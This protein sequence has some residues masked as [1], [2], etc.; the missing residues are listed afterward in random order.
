MPSAFN[1]D[2]TVDSS[3]GCKLYQ[4]FAY[5]MDALS[6]WC[7][8]YISFERFITTKYYAKRFL[9]KKKKLQIIFLILLIAFNILY[10]INII[11][12]FDISNYD[13]STIC[14]FNNDENQTIIA[15]MDLANFF[16]I[17]L[18][19]MLLFSILLI[20]TILKSR[21]TMNSNNAARE[22]RHRRKDIKLSISLLFLNLLFF[23]LNLPIVTDQ[24]L[25]FDSDKYTIVNYIYYSSY[26]VNFYILL[27]TNSLFRRQ[28]YSLF[29]KKKRRIQNNL[30]TTL[31]Q[32][33]AKTNQAFETSLR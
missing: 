32:N 26:G 24:F 10:H 4:F 12:S 33:Q 29:Y 30:E 28:F 11:F 5:G 2:P 16:L 13:N 20:A 9:Y 17:P 21:S 23:L 1:Y 14:F 8:I 18:F 25:P 19:L 22:N 6:P 7:L 15:N 27:G 31:N 3:I